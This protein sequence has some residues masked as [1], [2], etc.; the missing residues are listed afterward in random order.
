MHIWVVK[1]RK[2]FLHLPQ[3]SSEFDKVFDHQSPDVVDGG[4]G[5]LAARRVVEVVVRAGGIFLQKRY[6]SIFFLFKYLFK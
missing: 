3:I 1:G 5:A 6:H 4:H 2:Y